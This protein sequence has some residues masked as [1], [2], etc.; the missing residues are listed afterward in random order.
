VA[1][2]FTADEL[3]K[4]IQITV[5]GINLTVRGAV[6]DGVAKIGTFFVP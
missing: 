4:G 2:D 3:T 5:N 1:G 6:V